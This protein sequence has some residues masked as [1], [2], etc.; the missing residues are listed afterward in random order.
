MRIYIRHSDKEYSN[1]ENEIYKHDPGLS[2]IGLE[3]IKKQIKFLFLKPDKIFCSPY[4]RTRQTAELIK[5]EFLNIFPNLEI[6]I[7]IDTTISEYLGNHVSAAIDVRESTA[8][9][10]PPHPETIY[11]FDNRIYKHYDNHLEYDNSDQVILYVTHGIVLKKI[12]KYMGYQTKIQLPPCSIVMF[13]PDSAEVKYGDSSITL[14]P[15]RLY[16]PI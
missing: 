8:I 10:N 11:E 7:I 9:Y 13:K 5:T 3:N 16:Q 6:P 2:D 14:K 15:S 4:L 12:L 1:G